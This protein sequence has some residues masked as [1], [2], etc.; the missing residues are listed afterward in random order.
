MFPRE[1]PLSLI[2]CGPCA[3]NR[4]ADGI[5]C[6]LT[7]CIR[8]VI[9]IYCSGRLTALAIVMPKQMS[10]F[11]ERLLLTLGGAT[12]FSFGI[13]K[14]LPP[15]AGVMLLGLG[16]ATVM[17]GAGLF[18]YKGPDSDTVTEA[19]EE[20]FPASDPPAWKLGVR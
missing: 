13:R 8:L 3:S 7:F 9:T 12:L 4:F 18:N 11:Q 16:G 19:S 5:F 2:R 14:R 1:E 15:W 17:A 6:A 20:S 10:A